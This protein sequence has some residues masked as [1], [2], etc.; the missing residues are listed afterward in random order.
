MNR[1]G[2]WLYRVESER[3]RERNVRRDRK[4]ARK[5]CMVQLQRGGA[6]QILKSNFRRQR[7]IA[8]NDVFN[9]EVEVEEMAGGKSE[10]QR[11]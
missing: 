3:E 8:E 11:L 9:K 1:C 6:S 2:Y 4:R 7:A 5:C 10:R